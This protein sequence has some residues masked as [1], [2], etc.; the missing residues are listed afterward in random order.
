MEGRQGD[1]DAD[2]RPDR[3]VAKRAAQAW[4]AAVVLLGLGTGAIATAADSGGH[5][6]GTGETTVPVADRTQCPER[7]SSVPAE[8]YA[9]ARLGPG[10]GVKVTQAGDEERVPVR[11]APVSTMDAMFPLQAAKYANPCELRGRLCT[12]IGA[13]VRARISLFAPNPRPNA[14]TTPRPLRPSAAPLRPRRPRCRGG[15]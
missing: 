5:G 4:V 6:A 11:G 10:R 9:R 12:L 1:V 7:R 3:R 8:A 14:F 15:E 13:H 2:A